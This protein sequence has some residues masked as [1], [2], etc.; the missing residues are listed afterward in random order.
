MVCACEGGG[1]VNKQ[2]DSGNNVH[3]TTAELQKGLSFSCVPLASTTGSRNSTDAP[4]NSRKEFT[5]AS[6]PLSLLCHDCKH[7]RPTDGRTKLIF[8][9][10][11]L[12]D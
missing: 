8:E 3:G 9:H 5:L 12:S 10:I 11:S 2:Q 6:R 4:R 1:G 7:V